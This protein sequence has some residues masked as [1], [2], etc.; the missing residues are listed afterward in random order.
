MFYTSARLQA[1]KAYALAMQAIKTDLKQAMLAK[2]TTEKNTIRA[3]L[4]A[5]KNAEIDGARQSEF[6][7]AKVFRKMAKQRADSEALYRQQQRA[8][9]AETEAAERAHI[10]RYLDALPV[11]S[12][13]EVA[14]RAELLVAELKSGKT[15]LSMKDAMLAATAELAESWNTTPAAVK[16]AISQVFR[17]CK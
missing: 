7:L 14:K 2:N 6:E 17:T 12:E 11:A 8:D 3:V 10:A 4:A 15:D 16:A 13:A 5:V 1:T 9:L